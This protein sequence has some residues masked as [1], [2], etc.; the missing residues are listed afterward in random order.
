MIAA[1][2]A[3]SPRRMRAVSS[4][5][6]SVA[7]PSPAVAVTR[8]TLCP[9]LAS[10]ASAPAPNVS[11]SSGWAW[12]ARMAAMVR[13][14]RLGA[15]HVAQ[16]RRKGALQVRRISLGVQRDLQVREL[17]QTFAGI[18]ARGRDPVAPAEAVGRPVAVGQQ[19]GAAA[20]LQA[21][22]L[23]PH[24]AMLLQPAVDRLEVVSAERQRR[25][26]SSGAWAINPETNGSSHGFRPRRSR[27][28]W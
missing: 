20:V 13:L 25:H 1:A 11:M 27:S 21:P 24:L 4:G 6:V 17:C 28:A 3:A 15:R 2:A 26:Q 23:D 7:P 18:L 19:G 22:D 12:M 8:V 5:V 14:R 16:D 10:S 9:W